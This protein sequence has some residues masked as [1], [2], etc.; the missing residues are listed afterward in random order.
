MHARLGSRQFRVRG[1][2]DVT[3]I[4]HG[5]PKRQRHGTVVEKVH[6]QSDFSH[7][8]HR[9]GVLQNSEFP[10]TARINIIHIHTHIRI[11]Y[12][13]IYTYICNCIHMLLISLVCKLYFF[14][15]IIII[16]YSFKG[17]KQMKTRHIEFLWWVI[18]LYSIYM[19]CCVQSFWRQIL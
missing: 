2:T 11:T 5:H 8:R 19:H 4:F 18:L 15:C 16:V 13:Y 17:K 7:G 6:L 1:S 10:R 3:R 14:L 12:I 9:S